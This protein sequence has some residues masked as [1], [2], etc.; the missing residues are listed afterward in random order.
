MFR[1]DLRNVQK[2]GKKI[3]VEWGQGRNRGVINEN[4]ENEIKHELWTEMIEYSFLKRR[5]TEKA[6]CSEYNGKVGEGR[7]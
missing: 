5:S 7:T 6:I 2:E 1:K 3:H 4:W